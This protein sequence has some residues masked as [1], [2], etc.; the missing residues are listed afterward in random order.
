MEFSIPV[1]GSVAILRE[2]PD[3]KL[4]GLGVV[5][6]RFEKID[7]PEEIAARVEDAMQYVDAKRLSLNPDCGFAPGISIDMPLEEPYMKLKNEAEA[8]RRLRERYG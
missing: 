5:E 4:I 8:S 6:C 1:A 2:L 3:D 7:A